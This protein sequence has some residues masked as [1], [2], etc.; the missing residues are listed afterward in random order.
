MKK[1]FLIISLVLLVLLGGVQLYVRTDHFAT[2][3]RPY[4]LAPLHDVLGADAHI[5][6][7]GARFIPLSLEARDIV[8]PDD[9]GRPVLAV[10][11]VKVSINPLPFLFKKVRLPFITIQERRILAER[12]R[13]GE[14]NIVPVV[15]RIRANIIR[16]QSL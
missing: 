2:L 11:K 8:V 9:Q 13:E 4:V 10:R 12:S 16:I 3:I 5:G 1:F 7:I 6:W 15:E 14:I